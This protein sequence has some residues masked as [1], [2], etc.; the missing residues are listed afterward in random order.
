M[1][2]KHWVMTGA[3]PNDYA[4]D[5]AD[6]TFE[7]KRVVRL[8]SVATPATAFGAFCQAIAAGA[9]LGKRVRLS[10]ALRTTEVS[11]WAGLW[12]R[13]D[14]SHAG[15]TL[16]FDNM[17]QRA[18]TATTGWQRHAVVLDV[19]LRASTIIFGALLVGA[20]EVRVADLAFEEVTADVAVTGPDFA[21]PDAPR[22]LDFAEI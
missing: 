18:V 12:M 11:G 22:N 13:V 9:Y 15:E 19:D 21:V 4:L 17:E 14:G 7:G 2:P 10:G 1:G 8:Q 6:E 20:G 5:V 16:A 3:A